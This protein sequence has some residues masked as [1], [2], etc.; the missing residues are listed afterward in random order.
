MIRRVSLYD[1]LS[2]NQINF[3]VADDIEMP[4][5][6]EFLE[7]SAGAFFLSFGAAWIFKPKTIE[8]LFQNRL[9]NSHGTR[10]PNNRGGGGFSWQILMG[11]HFG[12]TLLHKVDSGIDT[13]PIVAYEEFLYPGALR[14]PREYQ[15][16]YTEKTFEFVTDLILKASKV[17][18]VLSEVKQSEYF[19]SYFP[20]LSTELNG[21]INW[22][23]TPIE[24]ERFICAFDE[25][26]AGAHT[27]LNGRVVYIKDVVL[28]PKDGNF[29]SF[30]SGVVY[31]IFK[32]WICVAV[33][34][35]TLVIEK[36]FDENGLSV[37]EMI[38]PG[39]RFI[40]PTSNLHE[41]LG[42]IIHT[43]NGIKS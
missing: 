9:L 16:L 3:I 42:R 37:L 19:S 31:R 17:E 1:F 34:G 30:Q 7:G 35:S 28:S 22:S 41:G 24:I 6:E 8:L 32:S 40:T 14:T 38:K 13:G 23:W 11:N 15:L 36:V 20:R 43:P 18:I 26:Y 29:H 10:L 2:I 27:F 33:P 25:P 5:V 12:F 21:W 4:E 39:D